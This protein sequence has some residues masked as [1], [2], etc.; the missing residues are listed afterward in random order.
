MCSCTASASARASS[1]RPGSVSSTPPAPR[2]SRAQTADR[3][4]A[5][6]C[7][8]T[9]GWVQ[10]SS[11]AAP[12][13][14]PARA[15]ARKISSRFGSISTPYGLSVGRLGFLGAARARKMVGMQTIGLIGGMSWHSTV[16]YYR[17]INELVA[18]RR[19][20]HASAKV[21]LQSLDFDEIR[22]CQVNGDWARAGRLLAEAA[23]RCEQGRRRPGADL[24]QPHAPGGRRRA[25]GHRH[26]AAPHRRRA[27]RP[28]PRAGLVDGWA[29]SAPAG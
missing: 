21:V 27:G 5:R 10:P 19:G 26:P 9:A 18:E 20:G 13:I 4:S 8:L 17:V 2:S 7:W 23:Q 15:T 11:R 3:S 28:G 14:E 12:L 24:H 1:T 16:E 25:G 29:C 22:E 6:R